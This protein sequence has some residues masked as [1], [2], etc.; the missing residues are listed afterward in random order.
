MVRSGEATGDKQTFGKQR[1]GRPYRHLA[2]RD[3]L[4]LRSGCVTAAIG[5]GVAL[6]DVSLREAR[7]SLDPGA[8]DGLE[9]PAIGGQRTG[10]QCITE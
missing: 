5:D 10:R 9:R 1:V 7:L 4:D 3:H 8:H 2:D 6:L